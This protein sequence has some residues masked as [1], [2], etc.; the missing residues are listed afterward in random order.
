LSSTTAPRANVT[1]R[2]RTGFALALVAVSLVLSLSA[3]SCGSSSTSA[4]SSSDQQ[5]GRI[6]VRSTEKLKPQDVTDGGVAGTGHFTITGAISDAGKAT[7]Y[8][9][10][11]GNKVLIRRVVAGKK[12]TITFL[13]T[14]DLRAP[15]TA[16][17]HWRITSATNG[18]KGLHGNGKQTID[19][20]DASPATFAL[21]GAVSQ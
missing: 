19:N 4:T 6:T 5:G 1:G 7:D 3:A 9:T 2:E 16:L 11:R 17:G 14:L 18:Y 12:G 10:E 15:T 8:R 21:A 20:F 13:I